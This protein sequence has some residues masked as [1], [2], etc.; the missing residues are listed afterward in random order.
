MVVS[1]YLILA[2]GVQ[3]M[4]S[5][6]ASYMQKLDDVPNAKR[7]RAN[8]ADLFLTNAV[9]AS[10]VQSLVQDQKES[11]KDAADDLLKAGYS[12]KW[13]N[14]VARDM[15]RCLKKRSAWPPLYWAKIR[16]FDLQMQC[17]RRNGCLSFCHMSLFGL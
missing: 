9:S 5:K 15:L 10:R 1:S 13:T 3:A 14:N 12:G 2:L 7:F 17:T 8:V 16:V 11:D 6:R 4:I